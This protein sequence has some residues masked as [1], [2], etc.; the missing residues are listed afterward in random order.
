MEEFTGVRCV[1]CPQAKSEIANLQSE[2]LFGENLIVVAYHAGFFSEPYTD[3]R[4]DYRTADG[5]TILEFLETPIGYPSAVINRKQFEGE[6][7]LQLIQFATWGG[8]VAQVLEEE[9]V[10]AMDITVDFSTGNRSLATTV[11]VRP[12]QN[13]SENLNLTVLITEDDIV[14]IQL[15]PDGIIEDYAQTHVFRAMLTAPLGTPLTDNLQVGTPLSKDFS[16]TLP[17]GWVAENCS[18]IAF[19]HQATEGKEVLQAAERKI[20]K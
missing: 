9:A 8:F 14:D 12:L 4:A 1:N 2:G 17:E 13:S 20:I 7:N 19:V 18:V 15:T 10:L 3:S 11:E 16:F 6:R 5:T